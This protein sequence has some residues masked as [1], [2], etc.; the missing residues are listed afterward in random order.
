M[1]KFDIGR[2]E[3]VKVWI[4]RSV[5]TKTHPG[6]SGS[7]RF[8]EGYQFSD[9]LIRF[10]ESNKKHSIEIMKEKIKLVAMGNLALKIAKTP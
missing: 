1:E 5:R 9:F 8:A 6:N 7:S 3:E 2:F 10:S 4:P